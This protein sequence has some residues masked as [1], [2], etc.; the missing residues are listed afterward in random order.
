MT[1]ETVSCGAVSPTLP[2]HSPY[3]GAAMTR[4]VSA[5]ISLL[6]VLSF[7]LGPNAYAHDGSHPDLGASPVRAASHAP[8]GVM[9]DHRHKAGEWM[10][11]YRYM[12]GG[13][14]GLRQGTNDRDPAAVLQSGGNAYRILPSS[15][16]MK[17]HMLGACMRR[18]TM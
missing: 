7:V 16:T 17:M 8:I 5:L 3:Q 4:N 12:Q 18:P 15:M 6:S 11:S 14:D 1:G 13:M 9:G 2:L 10:V